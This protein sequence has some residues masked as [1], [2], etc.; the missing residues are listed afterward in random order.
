MVARL[1]LPRVVIAAPTSGAGKTTIATGLMRALSDEGLC[2]SPHKVGP[3][4][5]DPSWHSVATGAPGR[6]LDPM[7]QGE[8][9]LN[10]LLR[11]GYERAGQRHNQPHADIAV[12]EGVMGLFDGALGRQGFAST[13]HVTTFTASPVI[14]VV[15]AA[16]TARSLAA[17]VH[18]FATYD[19]DVCVVGV[20]VNNVASARSESEIRD[21]LHGVGVPVLGMIPKDKS[22]AVPSRHLG[23]VTAA[24]QTAAEAQVEAMGALVSSHVDLA[25]VVKCAHG[26][27]AMA[28]PAWQPPVLTEP[29][30]PAHVVVFGGEAFTFYYAEHLEIFEALGARVTVIDPKQDQELP[31]DMSGL[32]IG[33]GFPECHAAELA[34]AQ[35]LR[36]DVAAAVNDGVPTYAEC[37]GYTYLCESLDGHPMAGV[38][39]ATAQMTTKLTMGYRDAVAVADHVWHS[40]GERCT[41]HEFHRTNITY[42]RN[43]HPTSRPAYQWKVDSANAATDGYGSSSCVASYLHQHWA[44]QS[45]QVARFVT[46]SASRRIE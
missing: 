17:T 4:Y 46:Q 1:A 37:G 8:Q 29:A 25:G 10:G 32:V 44:G 38:L 28:E 2:V 20:I 3:D 14:L 12:I 27:G 30:R 39:P 40:V 43:Q 11:Y 31:R 24:E 19:P 35:T 41:G 42:G 34:A 36:S 26:A 21:A 33:G 5:I 45:T 15:D 22:V 9:R 6:N 23:L 13:A 7:L 16:R 18:G